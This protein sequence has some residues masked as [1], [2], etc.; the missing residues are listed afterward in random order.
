MSYG[1]RFQWA[2]SYDEMREIFFKEGLFDIR[3]V[4]GMTV[5]E[6]LSAQFSLHTKAK[7]ESI[8]PEFPKETKV[9][10]SDGSSNEFHG[11]SS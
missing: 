7:I 2:K 10:Y 5:P 9:T 8:A 6:D 3:V 11:Y 1:V 4:P